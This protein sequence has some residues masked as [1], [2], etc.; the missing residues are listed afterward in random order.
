VPLQNHPFEPSDWFETSVRLTV[1]RPTV[2]VIWLQEIWT[3]SLP[4]VAASTS[5]GNRQGAGHLTIV[6]ERGNPLGTSRAET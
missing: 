6:R 5:Q 3:H 1:I 2:S 4:A